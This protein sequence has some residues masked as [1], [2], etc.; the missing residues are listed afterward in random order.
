MLYQVIQVNIQFKISTYV[1]SCDQVSSH[2]SQPVESLQVVR[3]VA[4]FPDITI[5]MI[6]LDW[7]RIEEQI[8]VLLH[9][10]NVYNDLDV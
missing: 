10:V 1:I 6:Q 9:K 7:P 2:R 5:I 8:A 3:V 4:D